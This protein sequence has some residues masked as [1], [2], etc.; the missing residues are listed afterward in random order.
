MDAVILESSDHL[1]ASAIANVGKA[2]I[3]MS[4]KIALKNAAVLGAV[5]KSAPALELA[6]TLGGLF[7]VQ[8]RHTPVVEVLAAAHGVGE[9]DAPVV[10]IID[11]GQSR[12]NTAFCHYGVR[13]SE[14]RFADHAYFDAGF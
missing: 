13:F 4:A 10:T 12:G 2:R 11:V 7:G 8:L 5:E 14:Q 9:M 3:A 1:K 6:H